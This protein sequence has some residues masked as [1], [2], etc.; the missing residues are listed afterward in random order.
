MTR[1]GIILTVVV[2]LCWCVIGGGLACCIHAAQNQLASEAA[3]DEATLKAMN[4]L[5]DCL[6][7][8][9]TVDRATLKAI[10]ELRVSLSEPEQE[11]IQ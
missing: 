8:D 3:A 9:A 10:E 6:A 11:Q 2:V 1:E 7:G 4:R 5:S